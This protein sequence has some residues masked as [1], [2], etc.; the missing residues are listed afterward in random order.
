MPARTFLRRVSGLAATV[1]VALLGLPAVA[2]AQQF[3]VKG[4][5]AEVSGALD[6]APEVTYGDSPYG[7]V[8]DVPRYAFDTSL[9]QREGF[10]IET[11]SRQAVRRA[12]EDLALEWTAG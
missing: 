12:A 2:S 7:W 1:M 4:I 9:M 11:T 3:D 6:L 10:S 8:G 5:V